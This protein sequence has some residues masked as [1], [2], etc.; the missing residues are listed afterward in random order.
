V[1]QEGAPLNNNGAANKARKNQADFFLMPKKHQQKYAE[2]HK[3]LQ[4]DHVL[5]I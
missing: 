3:M 5:L 4:E 1:P 2:T